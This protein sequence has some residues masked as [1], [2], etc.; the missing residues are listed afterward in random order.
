MVLLSVWLCSSE[1]L[2]LVSI[3]YEF[4]VVFVS[5]NILRSPRREV[6]GRSAS[7]MTTRVAGLLS[8]A[9]WISL[10]HTIALCSAPTP[11]G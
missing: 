4:Q 1:D 3:I 7:L 6:K 9:A 8:S 2:F 11:Y 10:S 5:G